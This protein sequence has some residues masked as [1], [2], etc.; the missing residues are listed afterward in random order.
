MRFGCLASGGGDL[1]FGDLRVWDA[2]SW[3]LV[4]RH[5]FQLGWVRSLAFSPDGRTLA[6]W[7][8]EYLPHMIGNLPGLRQGKC[9]LILWEVATGK[10]R[11]RIITE[12]VNA[13]V[14]AF[15][16]DGRTIASAGRDQSVR[17]WDLSGA[18]R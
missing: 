2:R 10:E 18:N 14:L 13:D 11:A 8:V 7:H 16:P 17:L 1:P 5:G 3:E 6:S 15:S 4:W 12:G 9:P